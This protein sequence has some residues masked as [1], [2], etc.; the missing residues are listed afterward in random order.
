MYLCAQLPSNM[1]AVICDQRNSNAPILSAWHQRKL[2]LGT[3]LHLLQMS[4]LAQS[5]EYSDLIA[6]N[7]RQQ[8]PAIHLELRKGPRCGLLPQFARI[9]LR[10][11]VVRRTALRS[12]GTVWTNETTVSEIHSDCRILPK[13]K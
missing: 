11:L 9:V 7:R 8:D 5:T 1:L 10:C 13:T 3:D 6:P 12:L 4:M 2:A